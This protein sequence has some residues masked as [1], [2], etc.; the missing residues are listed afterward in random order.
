MR[1]KRWRWWVRHKRLWWWGGLVV[2]GL[3]AGPL[4]VR[5]ALQAQRAEAMHIAAPPGIDE[6]SF[7]TIGG[8]PQWINVRGHDRHKPFVLYLDGGPGKPSTAWMH[9]QQLELERHVVMV[10]WEQRGAGKS[11]SSDI[12]PATMTIERFVQD[13][14]EVIDHLRRTYGVEKVVLLG[15]SWGTQLGVLMAQRAPEKVAAYIGVGQGVDIEEGWRR[16]LADIEAQARADDNQEELALIASWGEPLSPDDVEELFWLM[17]S[18][19]CEV[20]GQTGYGWVMAEML[21][22]PMYSL[23]DHWRWAQ[24][25]RFSVEHMLDQLKALDLRAQVPRLDVPVHLLHGR[26]DCN[27]HHAVAREWFEALEAPA[28]S[29]TWFARSAHSLPFEEPAR[30]QQV[31]ADLVEALPEG[32]ASPR[33]VPQNG[34]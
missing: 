7:V 2:A 24:G 4:L 31:V 13:G 34:G 16:T 23:A 28:K 32:V 15:H 1:H 19:G 33:S 26:Y 3:L 17:V 11:Y 30:F 5:A 20:H 6:S 29:F 21:V 12:D 10:H 27:T 25:N 18:H 9:L 8:V 14:I 22:S